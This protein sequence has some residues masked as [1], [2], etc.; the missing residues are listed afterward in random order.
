MLEHFSKFVLVVA[1][2]ASS[3]PAFG[4][5]AVGQSGTAGQTTGQI[6]GTARDS[7]GQPMPNTSVRLRSIETGRLAGSTTTS[8]TGQFSFS[9]LGPGMYV[10]EVVNA[11]GNVVATSTTISLAAG[12]MAATGVTITASAASATALAGGGAAAF[13]GSTAGIITLAALAGGIAFG[14]YE[15]TKPSASSAR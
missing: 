7:T 4:R 13:F 5:T 14:V 6:A 2:I 1:L 9:R 15:A 8:S 11:A 10:V 3:T 12:A